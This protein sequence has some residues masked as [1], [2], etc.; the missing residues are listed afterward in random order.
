MHQH[1]LFDVQVRREKIKRYD[2]MLAQLNTIID[3]ELFRPTLE[4]IRQKDH[5]SNAGRPPMDVVLMFKILILQSLYNLSDF[6]IEYQIADRFSFMTF[7]NLQL[8][9]TVPDEKTV[10][11]FRD[12]LTKAELIEPLF[13][14]FEA[15]LSSNGYA[16][17]K[18][19]IIDATI[20]SAPKQRNNREENKQ[21]KQ[22][23]TPEEWD[24]QPNKKRQK[25]VD[26]RWTKKRNVNY[27]GYKNHVSVDAKHKFIRRYQVSIASVHDSQVVQPLLDNSN[28]G[29][30]VW[31]DSAY[32]SEA[33]TNDLKAGGFTNQI[34]EKGYRNR[35]LTAQQKESNRKKSKTRVRVE[36]IFGV[37]SQ[38]AGN[39]ILR[40]IG[41]VRAKTKIGLRNLS[42]NMSRYVIL[43]G[44]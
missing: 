15:V 43:R 44:G 4:I 11:L 30:E 26:A 32:A 19:Q 27:F 41:I 2:N 9:D 28:P 40:G 42:Y 22:G 36:H 14:Q 12:Q 16:A 20:V 25:D 8:N 34:H 29:K 6:Q 10:W 5:K 1:G 31:G 7:L 17:Q 33:I 24:S 23:E 37:Q 13:E 3:W 38:R 35:P 18:G 21:I 39:L